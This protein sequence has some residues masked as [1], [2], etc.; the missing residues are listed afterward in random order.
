MEN[1]RLI[2]YIQT[3][4]AVIDKNMIVV[5][6]NDA[7]K[8]KNA[9]KKVNL[10]ATKCYEAAYN[11]TEPCGN[12][13]NSTCPVLESFKT[14]K[15]S[16]TIRHFSFDDQVIVEEVTTTPIIE[17]NGEVNYVVE[18]YRDLTKLLGLEKGILTICSYCRKIRDNDKWVAV[19]AYLENHTR[20]SFS[21]GICNECKNNLDDELKSF[22]LASKQSKIESD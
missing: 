4:V 17:E 22:D 11:F 19:E 3:A 12:K 13:M 9:H 21:H 6:S 16:S 15:S 10:V 1:F 2:N 20:T 5:D 14:K 18:E 7:Y 8:E